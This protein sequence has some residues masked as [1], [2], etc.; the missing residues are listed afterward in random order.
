MLPM[1]GQTTERI[2]MKLGKT[3]EITQSTFYPETERTKPR[4]EPVRT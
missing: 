4:A 3:P 1:N 2:A